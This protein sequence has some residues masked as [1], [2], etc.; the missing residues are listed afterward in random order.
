MSKFFKDLPLA[1]L[2]LDPSRRELVVNSPG[3]VLTIKNLDL[4]EKLEEGKIDIIDIIGGKA[5]IKY[6][7][8]EGSFG[9]MNQFILE[10]ATFLNFEI[11]LSEIQDKD[12]LLRD[13]LEVMKKIIIEMKEQSK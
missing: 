9:P 13:V 8:I 2:Q 4:P 12:I 11:G 10:L 3:C 7:Q 6:D 5:T 1:C